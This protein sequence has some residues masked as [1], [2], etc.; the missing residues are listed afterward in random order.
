M[1]FDDVILDI[2]EKVISLNFSDFSEIIFTIFQRIEKVYLL[3]LPYLNRL[4]FK[5]VNMFFNHPIPENVSQYE[6]AY[7]KYLKYVDNFKECPP[8]SNVFKVF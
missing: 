3:K 1:F 7:K 2:F 8:N 4:R 5:K 6:V